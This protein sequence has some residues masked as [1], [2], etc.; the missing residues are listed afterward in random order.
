MLSTANAEVDMLQDQKYVGDAQ[1]RDE[2]S[3]RAKLDELFEEAGDALDEW[4]QGALR[5]IDPYAA[6][7][8]LED[9]DAK[10]DGIRRPSAFVGMAA[11]RQGARGYGTQ[12]EAVAEAIGQP[13]DPRNTEGIVC[14]Q[15]YHVRFSGL[16]MSLR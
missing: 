4:A 1:T 11:G 9:L 14:I 3:S 16:R 7:A 6:L 12:Q 2:M 13:K 15:D 8:I 10:R 5:E